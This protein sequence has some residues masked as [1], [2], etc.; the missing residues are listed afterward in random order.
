[1]PDLCSGVPPLGV[2]SPF[3]RSLPLEEHGLTWVHPE[4]P[5]AHPLDDGTAV[6]LDRSVEATAESLGRDAAA[7]RKLMAPLVRDWD[8][9]ASQVLGPLLRVPRHPLALARFGLRAVRSARGL[10]EGMFEGE[11][12]R[13]LF[14]GLAAPSIFP[15]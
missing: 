1:M 5:L 10:A 14:A 11:R 8:K 3:F 2:G 13:A 6:V 9:L 7:Y 4:V 15:F 12:A